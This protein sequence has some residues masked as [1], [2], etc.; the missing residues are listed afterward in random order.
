MTFENFIEKFAEQFEEA[1][2]GMFAADTEFKQLEEWSSLMALSLIA[3]VDEEY[4][5][6]LKGDDI[7][8][9]KTIE[10]LFKIVSSKAK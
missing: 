5:V 7:K 1:E 8:N 9:S 10:D 4:D 3:M 2:P 6:T